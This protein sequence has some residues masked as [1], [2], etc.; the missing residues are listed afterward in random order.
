MTSTLFAAQAAA[1][2]PSPAE[3]IT[4]GL[5]SPLDESED[6]MATEDDDSDDTVYECPGLAATDGEMVV[7]NPFYLRGGD[8]PQLEANAVPQPISR[9]SMFHREMKGVN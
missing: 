7:N 5:L 4:D 8:L 3:H 2:M 9:G 1:L 6:A